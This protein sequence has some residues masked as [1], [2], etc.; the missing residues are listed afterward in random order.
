MTQ[1][2]VRL[3]IVFFTKLLCASLNCPDR[4]RTHKLIAV[5]NTN[6]VHPVCHDRV[7]GRG[8]GRTRTAD[9]CLDQKNCCRCHIHDIHFFSLFYQL[10]YLALNRRRKIRTFNIPSSLSNIICCACHSHDNFYGASTNSA[11]LRYGPEDP[12]LFLKNF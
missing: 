11:I 5:K 6:H 4:I 2:V 3:S 10:N 9:K 8:E 12:F 1:K 7:R